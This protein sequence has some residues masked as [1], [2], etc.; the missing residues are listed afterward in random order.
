MRKFLLS[1]VSAVLLTTSVANAQLNLTVNDKE[2]ITG[3]QASQ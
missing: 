3:L 2:P 1:A